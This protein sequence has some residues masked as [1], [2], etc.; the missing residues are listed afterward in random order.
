MR[1]HF[2]VLLLVV[3][4]AAFS[5]TEPG[6]NWDITTSMEMGGMKLP[7]QKQQV[8][9]SD[10]AEGPDAMSGDDK[11][12]TISDVKSSPG[13]YSYKVNCPDGSGIGEM[14][15]HGKDSYTSKMTLTADG[16]TMVMVSEGRRG[17]ACDPKQKNKQVAAMEAQAAA[18]M[19]QSCSASADMLLPGMLDT[20]TCAPKYKQQL[21]AKLNTQEGWQ[22]RQRPPAQRRADDGF[23]H[24]ASSGKI[25]WCSS[26]VDPA[27][28]LRGR[29]QA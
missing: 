5:Q 14:T 11:R 29:K 6:H 27:T 21:C 15:Y 28:A 3:A 8:C 25:L 9:I 13:K 7:G 23:R 16:E 22:T 26:R 4:P 2:A 19:Q 20:N 24:A 17:G 1:A 12:C 10:K 18:G